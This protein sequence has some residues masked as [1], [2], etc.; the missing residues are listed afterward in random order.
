MTGHGSASCLAKEP[1]AVRPEDHSGA[2]AELPQDRGKIG[3][4]ENSL[5]DWERSI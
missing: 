5:G 1:C 3:E 4:F 2:L